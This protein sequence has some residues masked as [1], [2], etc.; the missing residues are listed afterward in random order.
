ML[1]DLIRILAA[2]LCSEEKKVK[3]HVTPDDALIAAPATLLRLTAYGEVSRA[4]E[5]VINPVA[6][7]PDHRIPLIYGELPREVFFLYAGMLA[8]L[9]LVMQVS[10]VAEGVSP[11]ELENMRRAMDGVLIILERER[12]IQM[13]AFSMREA[14]D[15]ALVPHPAFTAG[16]MLGAVLG[17]R[18][19]TFPAHQVNESEPVKCAVAAIN[20]F[21]GQTVTNPD[22]SITVRML[23]RERFDLKTGKRIRK[24]KQP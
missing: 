3:I 15:P 17:L 21:G 19:T 23:R 13:C 1:N 11:E 22:G 2:A 5:A 18:E 12:G 14:P 9:N 20:E 6:R 8:K 4:G 10:R 24:K 16:A 7:V